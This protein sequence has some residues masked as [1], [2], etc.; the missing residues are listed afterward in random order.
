MNRTQRRKCVTNK[1]KLLNSDDELIFHMRC[2][3]LQGEKRAKCQ[4]T[5]EQIEA[6]FYNDCMPCIKNWLKAEA[7]DAVEMAG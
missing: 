4:T 7:K 1:Q 5:E 6:D 2:P 3:Y